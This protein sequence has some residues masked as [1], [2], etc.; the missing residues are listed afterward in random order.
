MDGHC[1]YFTASGSR[2]IAPH[3]WEGMQTAKQGDRM[4]MLLDPY[5]GR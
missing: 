1:F 2:N 5:Q 3:F 4:G